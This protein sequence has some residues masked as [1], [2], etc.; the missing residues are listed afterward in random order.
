MYFFVRFT[1]IVKIIVGILLMLAGVAAVIYGFIQNAAV[2]DL[3]NNTWLAGSNT[4]LLD[5]RFYMAVLG[6]ALFVIGMSAAAWGQLMLAFADVAANSR[7]ATLL[8][9]S[10][11]RVERREPA[12][13]REHSSELPTIS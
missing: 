9:R 4:R 5:A 2:V 8:L 10:M 6:L 11:R 13:S 12:Q 7:E 1:G 3:V